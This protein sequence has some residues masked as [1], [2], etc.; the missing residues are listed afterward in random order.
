M[1]S[2]AIIRFSYFPFV[3]EITGWSG[4]IGVFIWKIALIFFNRVC[5]VTSVK[6]KTKYSATGKE[7]FTWRKESYAPSPALSAQSRRSLFL[8]SCVTEL[9][10]S[11]SL[12]KWKRLVNKTE[13]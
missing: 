7:H 10:V 4:D 12:P 1:G 6:K 8:S 5:T 2:D 9:E 3:I 13:D 11:F